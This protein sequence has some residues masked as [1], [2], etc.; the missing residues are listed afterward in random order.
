MF[1]DLPEFFRKKFRGK[2]LVSAR[3]DKIPRIKGCMF[4]GFLSR[5]HPCFKGD[6][7]QGYFGIS[8]TTPPLALAYKRRRSG[9][10]FSS[11]LLSYT[12]H[13]LSGFFSPSHEKSFV[14][15]KGC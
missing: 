15:P 12:C 2:H 9:C 4:G 11:P 8:S 5:E 14:E 7:L 3:G 13:A 6:M 10:H 1:W